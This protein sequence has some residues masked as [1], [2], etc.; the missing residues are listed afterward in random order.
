MSNDQEQEYFSDGI[1]EEIIK[2]KYLEKGFEQHEG[3]MVF[4]NHWA[5]IVPWFKKTP[6][7]RLSQNESVFPQ[8]EDNL[9]T[10]KR[11]LLLNWIFTIV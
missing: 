10:E 8:N 3:M 4:I 6:G 5:K 11:V 2:L 1:T 7:S 9:K